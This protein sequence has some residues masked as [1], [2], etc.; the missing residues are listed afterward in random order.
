MKVNTSHTGQLGERIAANYLKNKGY[1]I[2]DMNFT[3]SLGRKLGEIDII[4]RDLKNDEIVFT[5]VKARDYQKYRATLPEENITWHKIQRLSKIA[6]VYLKTRH[7]LESSYRFDAI[8]V[9]IDYSS[10]NAKVKHMKN[11]Y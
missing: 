4:A 2:L 8:S 10:R 7:L 9:W 11:I 3:N 6:Q 5:E 1:E